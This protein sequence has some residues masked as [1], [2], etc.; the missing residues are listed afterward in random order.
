[1]LWVCLCC[2]GY[3]P[4][5]LQGSSAV[6]FP[7]HGGLLYHMWQLCQMVWTCTAGKQTDP[8]QYWFSSSYNRECEEPRWQLTVCVSWLWLIVR[9]F[10]QGYCRHNPRK[11]VRTWAEKETRNLHRLYR[12]G[13][14]CPQPV[15]HKEHIVVMSFIGENGR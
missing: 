2:L 10:Q 12:A 8:Q 7:P 14:A 1:M 4:H 6:D 13:V 11:M 15:Y 9:R 3:V 5:D